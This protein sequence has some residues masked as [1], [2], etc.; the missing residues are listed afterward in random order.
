M[1]SSFYIAGQSGLIH[2]VSIFS[3]LHECID[4]V[5]DCIQEHLL[6]IEA[7]P[8]VIENN[9]CVRLFSNMLPLLVKGWRFF[10]TFVKGFS[11]LPW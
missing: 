10:I 4:D 9:S 7:L 1:I 5:E 3:E 8:K 11:L 2:M 6:T